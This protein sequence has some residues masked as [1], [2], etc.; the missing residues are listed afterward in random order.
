MNHWLLVYEKSGKFDTSIFETDVYQKIKSDNARCYF[1]RDGKFFDDQLFAA[2]DDGLIV[3]DGVILNLSE[4]KAQLGVSSLKQV[5]RNQYHN[6]DKPFF[7]DFIGPFCG[8]YYDKQSDELIVYTNHT[9][10]GHIFYYHSAQT[11]IV[12]NDCNMMAELLRANKVPYTLDERA[13]LYLLTYGYMVDERTMFSEIKRVLPGQFI[14]LNQ[15]KPQQKR[16]HRFSFE[17]KSC[18]FEEA[19][20]LVDA[21]FRK[22]VKR[23]FDKDREYGAQFHWL[24]MSGGLDSRMTAWVAKDMGYDPFICFSYAQSGSDDFR[25]AGKVAERLGAQSY[26]KQLDDASF[27]Y[28]IDRIVEQ[29]YGQNLWFGFTGAEQLLRII[30]HSKFGLKQTGQIGDIVIGTIASG[31]EISQL[32]HEIK[33]SRR[34]PVELS[35]QML[36]EFKSPEEFVLYTRAF[37]GPL[38][39]HLLIRNYMYAVSPF[40]DPEF[41]QI[42]VSLPMEYRLN[43]KLYWAWIDKKYPV[44][45]QIPSTRKRINKNLLIRKGTSACWRRQD[46][47]R[48]GEKLHLRQMI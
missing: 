22:A 32:Q 38:T 7:S 12:S 1:Q 4:L 9:G 10:D 37:M 13:V 20:E 45:G 35:A 19:I 28:D 27:L 39:A 16:Y 48:R 6:T 29:N 11:K 40:A 21:G 43:H 5:I 36:S 8:V 42:C 31:G 15:E 3:S 41:F 14:D 18:S 47:C 26:A 25:C 46:C 23:C 24:D 33:Y 34:L 2:G 30:D 44:A 17:E